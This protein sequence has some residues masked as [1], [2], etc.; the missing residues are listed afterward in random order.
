MYLGDRSAGDRKFHG[1]I[2]E[3]R[4]SNIARSTGW[5]TTCY[6]NQNNPTSFY[7]NGSEEIVPTGYAPVISNEQ[8]INGSV[9]IPRALSQLSFILSDPQNDNINYTITTTPDIIG[10]SHH[11]NDIPSGSTINI[12]IMTTPLSYGTLYIW[13][14][15]STDGKYWTNKTFS[16]NT[17]TEIITAPNVSNASPSANKIVPYNPRLTI[18]VNDAQND[19]LTVIF[20]T[21]A[22]GTWQ[23]LGTYHDGNNIYAQNTSNMDIKN[24]KYYWSISVF[25]GT[26]WVNNTYSLSPKH[27][28]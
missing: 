2:D 4:L 28:Y 22:S 6:H 10:G 24:K 20:K 18:T 11:G 23:T 3:V 5:I 1:T 15:N 8:P 14:I 25:D 19:P 13:Q 9:N 7:T 21:N 17:E 12:P 16:F 27:S 26:F